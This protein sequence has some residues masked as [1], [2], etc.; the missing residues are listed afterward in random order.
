MRKITALL[1]CVGLTLGL[2]GCGSNTALAS[3]EH[4][5]S[6]QTAEGKTLVVYFSATGHTEK[7]ANVIAETLDA[8]VFEI[9]PKEPYTN[10]DLNW[11]DSE[12]RVSREHED[13]S[14][15]DVDLTTTEADNWD[16]YTTVFIGY[17]IWWGNAAWPVTSFVKANDFT[18]KTVI[19]FATSASS[20][21][22]QSG[23]NLEK[24]AGTGNWQDGQRFGSGVTDEDVTGWL[25]SLK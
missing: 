3:S 4:S 13:E 14:L 25:E 2:Y 5:S 24:A 7:V 17:P 23:Q 15:Q 1:V 16:S 18:D 12:S 8:D 19:P 20:G 22:G 9:T 6:N 21:I 11:S 10:E